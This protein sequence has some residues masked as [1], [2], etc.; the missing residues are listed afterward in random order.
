MSC[1]IGTDVAQAAAI[2]QN[3]GLV[4]FATETVYGLGANALNAR[5]VARIFEVKN[6]PSFDPIIV[7]IAAIDLLPKLTS[8]V[9]PRAEK[10]AEKFWPGPMT[11]VLPKSEIVP[12]IVTSGLPS[13]G[14]RMPG[15]PLA[16]ELLRV[17]GVSV[18]AP[19][20]NPFG[21]ISP[22]RAEHVAEMLGDKIEY[23]LDG[24]ACRVG[25]ESTVLDLTC[26]VPMLL[27]PGGLPVEE[28]ETV[29]GPV[30]LPRADDLPLNLA[31]PAPGMLP[32]HYAPRTKLIVVAPNEKLPQSLPSRSG[33]LAFRTPSD[34][35]QFAAVEVLSAAGD[36]TEAAANFF[37]ALRRLDARGLELIVA[38]SFPDHGLGRAL[39]DRLQRAAHSNDAP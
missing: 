35:E 16:L 4:A 6:R 15:H 33:L 19:S 22:T 17:A 9:P 27:R 26:D 36:L 21:K 25:V 24:G 34:A 11:M 8:S 10:L 38:E 32:R 12:D 14:I 39:N 5:A 18:A 28:I 20:A 37:A 7:H 2:L 1:P 31:M 29:I 13:V 30:A 3:G 23:I